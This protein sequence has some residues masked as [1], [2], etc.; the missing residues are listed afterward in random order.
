[1]LARSILGAALALA[2]M[3]AEAQ[4]LVLE[5]QPIPEFKAVYG[6]VEAKD[7]VPAR[8]RIGG[9]L[10]SLLVSEGDVVEA[11][12]VL[13]TVIDEKIGFQLSALD[14]R[15]RALQSEFENA[16][17]ELARAEELIQRG[18]TTTQ[19]RDALQ[20][21]VDVVRNNIA[22]AEQERN[23]LEQRQAEG[24]VVAPEAGRVVTV[25]LTQG[26]VVLPGEPVA[27][28][29]GGGNFLRLAIPERH[30]DTLSEG[31]TIAIETEA[32]RIEGTLAKIYPQIENGRV[33][34]DVT[35]PELETVLLN[36]RVLV[37]VPLGSREALMLPE[38]AVETR[39]GLD[40][41]T[42]AEG[43]EHA[44]RVVMLGA[45]REVEGAA[46]VEVLSG[47]EAGDEVVLP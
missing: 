10:E 12:Q 9:T 1:M 31:A 45:R 23:V 27:T 35:M 42:V 20:T 36:A 30:R 2:A 8:A 32:G 17:S 40:I 5:P 41:V 39:F 44:E 46:M 34:A 13:A 47:L 16:Q 25:P 7:V 37:R 43:A 18:A 11:G 21:Q 26:A 24:A 28:I 29:G 3:A 14:A 22:A 6:T 4:T 15:L 19:R 33:I 38:E